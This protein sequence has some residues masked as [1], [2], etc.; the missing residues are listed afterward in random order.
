M[1]PTA[2]DTFPGLLP[3]FPHPSHLVHGKSSPVPVQ[4]PDHLRITLSSGNSGALVRLE[5]EL[6]VAGAPALTSVL[7]LCVGQPGCITVDAAGLH[8]IDAAGVR[9]LADA[10]ALCHRQGRDFHVAPASAAVRRVVMLTGLADRLLG[11]VD[12]RP[13]HAD[14]HLDPAL[15]PP[16]GGGRRRTDAPPRVA[17]PPSRSTESWGPAA[18]RPGDVQRGSARSAGT[19]PT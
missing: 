4:I 12:A 6:D 5:G 18:F 7:A 10:Q 3:G 11:D 1:R 15:D 16:L 14:Q 13:H 8:F 17:T 2:I 9:P 19:T